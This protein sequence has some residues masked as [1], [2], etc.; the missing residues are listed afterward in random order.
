MRATSRH[1]TLPKR[2]C[3]RPEVNV[4]PI[5]ARCTLADEAAGLIPLDSRTVLVVTPKA[6]PR[7]PSTSCPKSPASA[8]TSN[9]RIGDL[10]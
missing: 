5:S 7:A 10:H 1:E 2:Q 6:M 3:D 8:N 9:R 4:V